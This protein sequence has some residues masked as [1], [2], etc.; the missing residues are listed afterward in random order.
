MKYSSWRRGV[1]DQADHP[2]TMKDPYAAY[3]RRF[4]PTPFQVK[5]SFQ[6]NA[7]PAEG[8]SADPGSLA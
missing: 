1:A 7:R 3:V 5:S 2:Y 8:I 6:V 4:N